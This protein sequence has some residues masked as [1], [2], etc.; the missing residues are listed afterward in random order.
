MQ[1]SVYGRFSVLI[2]FIAF[3]LLDFAS[4]MLIVFGVV[5]ALAATWTALALRAGSADLR[6]GR[7][8]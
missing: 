7:S 5:D 1:A 8:H 3:V 4:P 2:F 6:N